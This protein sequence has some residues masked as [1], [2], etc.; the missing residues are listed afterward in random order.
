[1]RI[2]IDADGCPVVD[3]TLRLAGRPQVGDGDSL[4]YLSRDSAAGGADGDGFPRG[5][6]AWIS[7]WVNRLAPGDVV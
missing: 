2:Y 6:N 1:M 5:R 3:S 4:R 7:P